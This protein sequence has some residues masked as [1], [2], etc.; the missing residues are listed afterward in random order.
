MSISATAEHTGLHWQTV[1]DIEKAHLAKKYAK[2]RLGDVCRL[3]I[4]EVYLGRTFGFIT[5]VRDLDSGAVLFIGKGKGGAAV[6]VNADCGK[7]A[8][9]FSNK[10][11]E[12]S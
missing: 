10:L 6:T 11:S 7:S 1:K 12:C 9:L 5:I 2:I 3:G 4:D 8:V